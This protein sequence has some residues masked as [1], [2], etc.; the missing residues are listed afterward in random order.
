MENDFRQ[1]TG[2]LFFFSSEEHKPAYDLRN[3]KY[4]VPN[5]VFDVNIIIQ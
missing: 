2:R 4:I 1:K 3:Y 5:L